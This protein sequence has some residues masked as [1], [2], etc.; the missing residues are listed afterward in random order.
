[1]RGD[2]HPKHAALRGLRAQTIE[3]LTNAFARDEL[4][5]EEFEARLNQAYAAAASPEL[6]AL[7]RDLSPESAVMETELVASPGTGLASIERPAQGQ[8]AIA[9]LGSV[10]RRGH[11]TVARTS[12]ALAVLGSVVIDLRDVTL[13]AGV[14]TL[15]VSTVLGSIEI[16]VPP[17]LAVESEGTGILGSFEGVQRLPRD[18]D[19][20]LPVLRVRGRAVLGSIEVVTRP[21]DARMARGAL[22]SK[23]AP[24]LGPRRG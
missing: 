23:T 3:Q 22:R 18:L 9:I 21:D 11:W 14:T 5:L 20:D 7:V 8:R 2:E 10:E 19:P 13:P 17:N 24:S 6:A 12:S 16:L 15:E 1:M 4:G